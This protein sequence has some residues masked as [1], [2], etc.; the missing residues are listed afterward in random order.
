MVT[1][2][3]PS[4]WLLSSL[5]HSLGKRGKGDKEWAEQMEIIKEPW[6]ITAWVSGN[7]VD[8][9]VITGMDTLSTL[10][11]GA[12][13][14]LQPHG[15]PLSPARE[16]SACYSS[17]QGGSQASWWLLL[18]TL[19]THFVG[20]WLDHSTSLNYDQQ[21]SPALTACRVNSYLIIAL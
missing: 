4:L 14:G 5:S 18:S 7:R 20:C 2:V 10:G 1:K 6:G 9:E 3:T 19:T 15:V 21:R 12:V 13:S 17:S 16:T 11:T 8:N